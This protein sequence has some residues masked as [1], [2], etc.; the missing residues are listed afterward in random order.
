MNPRTA[1][2]WLEAQA[3]LSQHPGAPRI[4]A[5]EV[6]KRAGV[7]LRSA[8]PFKPAIRLPR[9]AKAK[10]K[11]VSLPKL[12]KELDRVFSIII[13]THKIDENGATRCVTCN[14]LDHWKN[15]DAG[16]Y[17][18]RQ[19]LAT[20]WDPWNVWPQCKPCNGFR[21]GE[22]EKMAAYIDRVHGDG[23]AL[24]LREKSKSSFKL[25]RSWLESQIKWYK[26]QIG[27]SASPPAGRNNLHNPIVTLKLRTLPP[28]PESNA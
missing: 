3:W 7:A 19:D 24:K 23:A 2:Q 27:E 6:T 8:K 17:V 21:G 9:G 15:M 20:R 11:R 12:K 22:P 1:A 16:H 13:R 28:A 10:V 26:A 25:Q 14:R 18:P 5:Q 4:L